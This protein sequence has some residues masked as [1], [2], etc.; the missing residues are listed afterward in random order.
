MR[1]ILAAAAVIAALATP[2][3]AKSA[4]FP[5]GLQGDWCS[6][7]GHQDKFIYAKGACSEENRH[8]HM[9]LSGTSTKTPYVAQ[10]RC[11]HD[12]E[13]YDERDDFT[14]KDDRLEVRWWNKNFGKADDYGSDRF[15]TVNQSLVKGI[16]DKS[17]EDGIEACMNN[18]GY[19]FCPD[20]QVFGNDGPR[21]K[22]DDH[23]HSWCWEQNF[24]EAVKI[25]RK[26][27]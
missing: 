15:T 11:S 22:D 21:C 12:G 4:N 19:V 1:K 24:D 20:C 5:K 13:A 3:H 14:F 7:E 6:T 9:K 23:L 17:G 27:S 18:Q 16:T 2:A 8:D 26:G 25:M 10:M